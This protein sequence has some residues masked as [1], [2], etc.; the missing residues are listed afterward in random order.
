MW[1]IRFFLCNLLICFGVLGQRA[2]LSLCSGSSS[3]EKNTR[4]SLDFLGKKKSDDL[5]L[6]GY[7][8]IPSISNNYLWFDF[9]PSS[10]GNLQIVFH[11]VPDSTTVFIFECKTPQPCEEIIE[12]KANLILCNSRVSNALLYEVSSVLTDVKS[13]Y[14]IAF[15]T[16]KGKK[17]NVGF[18]LNFEEKDDQGSY[19]EDSLSLNL[20]SRY[21]QPIYALHL[22][23]QVTNQPIVARIYLSSS[24]NL[25]GAYRASDLR[26]NNTKSLKAS[27]RI[28]AQGYFSKDLTNH[29]IIGTQSSHDTIRLLPIRSGSIAKL[30]DINFIG[31]L[32]VIAEESLSKLKRLKDFL[33]L[34]PSISIEI[35]GHVNEEGSNSIN[36]QRLSKKRAQKIMKYLI[37]NGINSNRL[38]AVGFGN[39]RPLF[40][41]PIDDNQREANRRVEIKV[42]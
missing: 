21:D 28:D 7:C 22:V 34:N 13:T 26:I 12:K 20:V 1:A 31:G 16:T 23:D 6:F 4:Y 32:A 37:Q 24:G 38:S 15:N 5:N 25:D 11:N 36:S 17:D 10:Y 19:I 27:M 41:S 42:N 9:Q 2:N 29:K 33:L 14:Y 39:S 3:V 8:N 40:E 35:Q 30:E 18:T